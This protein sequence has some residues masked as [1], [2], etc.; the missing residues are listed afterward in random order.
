[1]T[2]KCWHL[3]CF[4]INVILFYG[5]GLS[6][7]RTSNGSTSQNIRAIILQPE[8]GYKMISMEHSYK[9]TFQKT[10][11]RKTLYR[12]FPFLAAGII[13]YS[14]SVPFAVGFEFEKVSQGDFIEMMAQQP[15]QQAAHQAAQEASKQ[16][17]RESAQQAAK[18]TAE[19]QLQDNNSTEADSVL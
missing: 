8:S 14:I 18:E 6:Q 19:D 11:V 3:I 5:Y 2:W 15:A 9:Q 1:M 12:A 16:A 10:R 7:T 17:A 4:Y 13:A